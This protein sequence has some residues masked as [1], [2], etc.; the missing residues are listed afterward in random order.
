MRR[1]TVAP[2]LGKMGAVASEAIEEEY[3]MDRPRGK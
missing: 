3:E 2:G 1:R